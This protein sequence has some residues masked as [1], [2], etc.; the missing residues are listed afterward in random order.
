M[1]ICQSKLSI[2]ST[3]VLYNCC[4]NL[5]YIEETRNTKNYILYTIMPMLAVNSI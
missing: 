4:F 2:H 5:D 1:L 3:D